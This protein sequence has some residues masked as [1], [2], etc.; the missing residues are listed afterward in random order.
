MIVLLHGTQS[1]RKRIGYVADFCPVCLGIQPFHFLAVGRADHVFFVP[2]GHQQTDFHLRKCQAC[3]VEL[4]ATPEHYQS[5]V[6]TISADLGELVKLT[7]PRI[8]EQNVQ[9]I[10]QA[11]WLLNTIPETAPVLFADRTLQ[12]LTA[13]NPMVERRYA[14]RS[15]FDAYSSMG[16]LGTILLVVVFGMFFN[17]DFLFGLKML[18]AGFFVTVFLV[19]GGAR[20][21][22]RREV[23]PGLV[24]GFTALK[25]DQSVIQQAL[26]RAASLGLKIGKKVQLADLVHK[27]P[28]N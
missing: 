27:K 17:A 20:R 19:T 8:Q 25:A 1:S 2:L 11:D 7:N 24:I 18:V 6:R 23:V 22:I 9:A 10:T 4:P 12:V 21:F 28:T 16:C 5:T 3:G 14:R 13:F 15:D 26:D